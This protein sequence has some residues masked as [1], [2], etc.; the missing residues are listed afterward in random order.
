M[1]SDFQGVGR[2]DLQP[3]APSRGTS[4]CVTVAPV[5]FSLDVAII[6]WLV[7][8]GFLGKSQKLN[9]AWY[10]MEENVVSCDISWYFHI[11]PVHQAIEID[12]LD[13]Q[14]TEEYPR[15]TVAAVLSQDYLII[16][17]PLNI[18]PSPHTNKHLEESWVLGAFDIMVRSFPVILNIKPQLK[19]YFF[20]FQFRFHV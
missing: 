18:K 16:F 17:S 9:K 10:L 12:V 4:V 15:C 3:S 5:I 19:N 8:V 6:K 2:H 14:M 11:F 1:A 7:C 20:I 13:C